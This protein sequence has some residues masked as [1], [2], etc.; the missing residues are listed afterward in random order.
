MIASLRGRLVGADRDG[1]VVEVGGAIGLRV[2]A[3][4]S[5]GRLAAEAPESVRLETHL[6]VREDV[7]AL[8]GFASAEER[9]LFLAL[10]GVGGVGPKVA[11]AVV[12][13]Y[14]PATLRGAIASEDVALLASITGIGRKTATRIVVELRGRL[15]SLG[16]PG[17]P[18]PGAPGAAD[19]HALA[20][21]ALVELGYAPSEAEAALGGAAGTPEERVRQAL[22]ALAAAS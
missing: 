14:P 4:A 12:S 1:L 9:S 17:A 18:L 8:Y 11:L 15:D 13:A 2:H 21:Q 6:I 3:T 20:R 10:L 19:E 16:V 7:L 5:A 22:L